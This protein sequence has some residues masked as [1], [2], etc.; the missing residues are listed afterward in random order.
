MSERP[1]RCAETPWLI[2]PREDPRKRRAVQEREKARG[3]KQLVLAA[4]HALVWG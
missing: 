4:V 1:R 2:T 3:F